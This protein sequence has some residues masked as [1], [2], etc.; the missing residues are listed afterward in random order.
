MLIYCS[1]MPSVNEMWHGQND[2]FTTMSGD[3]N[4]VRTCSYILMI[5]IPQLILSI[6]RF[7]VVG[8]LERTALAGEGENILLHQIVS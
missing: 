8:W 6:C 4:T 7:K 2:D 5:Y 3:G 1:Y